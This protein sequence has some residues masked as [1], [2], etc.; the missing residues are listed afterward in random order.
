LAQEAVCRS[1]LR[2]ARFVNVKVF[3]N[4]GRESARPERKRQPRVPVDF[5]G[6]VENGN[7][8]T[9]AAPKE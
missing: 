9:I 8:T 7:S 5:F 2:A 6:K 1:L 3:S 4:R